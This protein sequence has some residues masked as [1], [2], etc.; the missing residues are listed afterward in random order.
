MNEAKRSGLLWCCS[1]CAL[2][3]TFGTLTGPSR[4]GAQVMRDWPYHNV[5]RDPHFE[6]GDLGRLRWAVGTWRVAT[7]QRP[8]SYEVVRFVN[9]STISLT[10]YADDDL[11]HATGDAR[12]YLSGG[13]IFEASGPSRWSATLIDGHGARFRPVENALDEF[14]WMAQS[15]DQWTETRRS[16]AGGMER[17]VI[18][19][20]TRL[21]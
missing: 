8:D 16:G 9:D 21:R 15:A 5:D 3:L 6:P 4:V 19:T 12:I 17:M 13:R 11:H 10:Y 1:V 7:P 14:V 18:S 20:M 2:L